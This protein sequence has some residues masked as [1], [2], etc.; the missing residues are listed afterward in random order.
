MEEFEGDREKLSSL[1]EKKIIDED[2]DLQD[3]VLRVLEQSN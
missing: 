3:D 2:G 1:F